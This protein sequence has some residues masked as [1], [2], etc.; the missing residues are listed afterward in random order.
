MSDSRSVAEK[1]FAILDAVREHR[2]GR[3]SLS[4]IAV[5]ANLPVSTAHRLIG[6]WVAWGGLD[7]E[8]DGTYMIGTKIWET[9]VA[10]PSIQSLRTA[11]MPFLRDLLHA[12]KQ[13][14]QLAIL[15]GLDALYVEKLS[16]RNATRLVSR[17]GIRLPLHATGVGLILLAHAGESVVGE[18]LSQDLRRFTEKTVVDEQEIRQRLGMIR[19]NGFVRVEEELHHGVLSIAAPV[20]DRT[21]NT[22]AAMSI[23]VP[24]TENH[25][26]AMETLVQWGAR[27]ASR[28]LGFK[29]GDN[30]F[31]WP[32]AEALNY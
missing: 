23:V 14:A 4:E 25:P 3:V 12:T 20:S 17:Q 21:G 27:G 29:R 6:E 10:S 32:D 2:L 30:P 7:R 15:Q 1:L 24:V 5:A 8:E 26:P 28:M 16:S 9:G 22:I 18:Y 11:A 13:H 19:V 31:R